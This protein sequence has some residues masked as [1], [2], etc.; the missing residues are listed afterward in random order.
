MVLACQYYYG[1]ATEPFDRFFGAGSPL[2]VFYFLALS[3]LAGTLLHESSGFLSRCILSD[4]A[5]EQYWDQAMGDTYRSVFNKEPPTDQ[6]GK[7]NAGREIFHYVQMKLDPHKLRLFSAFAAMSRTM[8]LTVLI[9]LCIAHLHGAALRFELLLCLIAAIFIFNW[10]HYQ[11]QRLA[12]AYTAF[13]TMSA[14]Q[15]ERAVA[16][17]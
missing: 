12:Y 2:L 11:K 14:S 10:M 3:Y 13:L 1:N 4:A 8:L 5:H 15:A 9:I 7:G 17:K 16:A 6:K